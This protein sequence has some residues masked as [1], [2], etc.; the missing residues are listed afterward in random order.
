[1][2]G[3]VAVA[4]MLV[5]GV[6]YYYSDERIEGPAVTAADGQLVVTAGDLAG[7]LQPEREFSNTVMLF[8][9]T[10]VPYRNAISPVLVAGLDIDHAR[11]IYDRYPDFYRC[12]SPG[13]TL[14]KPLVVDINVIPGDARPL[15]TVAAAVEEFH[16]N[17]R[18]GG[19]RVC[20]SLRGQIATLVSVKIR[21]HGIDI[22]DKFPAKQ[23]YF[24]T[25]A[26]KVEC[27]DVLE[28]I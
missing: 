23:Y 4:L 8:G 12:K 7:Y 18:T 20:M 10:V 17:L 21:E 1:M 26:E 6:L 27:R 9:G 3:G 24:V 19:D 25:D 5:A 22:T 28:Q 14:A 16:R 13:A 15:R 2:K 11:S